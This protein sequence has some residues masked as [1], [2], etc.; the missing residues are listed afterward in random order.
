MENRIQHFLLNTGRA[1]ALLLAASSAQAEQSE[2]LDA[3][4]QPVAEKLSIDSEFFELGVYAGLINIQDFTTNP[5]IGASATFNA[6]EDF[7]LQFN[8]AGTTEVSE[9]SYEKSQGVLFEGDERNYS[10]YDF[11]LGYNV[12]Q[13]EAFIGDGSGNWSS[14]YLVAGVGNTEFGGEESF[15]YTMGV[16]Y[17]VNLARNYIWRVDLRDHTYRSNLLAEDDRVHNVEFSTGLSYVF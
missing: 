11:L 16:G 6:S 3:G 10:Y 8:L 13:G 4:E 9:S 15:T 12:F 5:L 14:L 7:F 2:N 17:K 1:L